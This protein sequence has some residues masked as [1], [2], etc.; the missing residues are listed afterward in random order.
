MG[1]KKSGMVNVQEIAI[2][3]AV[4]A[5]KLQ[6]N[7]DRERIRKN[8]FR[9]TELLLKNYLSLIEHFEMSQDKVSNEDLEVY[10]FEEAEVEDIIIGAIRRSRIRTL[11]MVV[12]IEVCLEKL[13]T[14]MI[15]KGQP[16][17]YAVIDKLYLDPTKSSMPLTERKQLVAAEIP[18]GETSVWKWRNEMIDELS[19]SLFGVDGLRLEV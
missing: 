16:E 12:Q 14:K 5:L 9:N 13:R 19:V 18:C 17:K 8:R 10:N 11:I 4:E 6:K 15:G 1:G 7:E 2:A 3:A